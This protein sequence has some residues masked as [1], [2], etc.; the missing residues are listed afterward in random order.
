V[1]KEEVIGLF[2]QFRK[3]LQAIVEQDAWLNFECG[4]TQEEF[5]A[6]KRTINKE[7]QYNPWFTKDNYLLG[8]QGLI[9]LLEPN[10]LESFASK[11][12]YSTQPKKIAVIMA[13]NIPFVGF[14]DLFCVLL[15]GNKALVK[16]SS[17][18]SRVPM[19]L[20]SWLF[21]WNPELKNYIEFAHGPIAN[22]DA[23]IATGSNNTIQQ[24]SQY[25]KAVPAI[26]RKNRTSVAVLDGAE[27]DEEL[28]LLMNDCFQFFGLG[29]RNVSKLFLPQGFNL[30]RIFEN[31]LHFSELIQH[32]KYGN[33]YDYQRTILMMNQVPFLDNN[34][35]LLKED[36]G[37]HAPLA[38]I[39]YDYYSDFDSLT[40][41]LN[42][43]Q[44][45]LQAVVGH[46]FIPF[47]KAQQPE[48]DDFADNIDTCKWLNNL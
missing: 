4:L 42:A 29:C 25:I 5:D 20:I 1:K 39:Y 35:F 18:D 27:S 13:G 36:K 44:D 33:N 37:L 9:H 40:A 7:V 26:Y 23:V 11:Y 3:A 28:K 48:I 16:L 17:S 22:Y 6:V 21:Q 46:D 24:L 43:I 32:H 2:H 15:T 38:V 41:E 45:V 12:S 47:G 30:N 19:Q 8:L 34:V 31:S 10:Q 14:H